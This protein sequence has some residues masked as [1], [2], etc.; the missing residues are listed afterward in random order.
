MDAANLVVPREIW[1][2]RGTALQRRP[3]IAKGVAQLPS[4]LDS[5]FLF[6][7][8]LWPWACCL[9]ECQCE[10]WRR[11]W[12]KRNV[13]SLRGELNGRVDQ[14]QGNDVWKNT[15]HTVG[16]WRHL[17][18]SGSVFIQL[19]G[20]CWWKLA[21]VRLMF[22]ACFVFFLWCVLTMSLPY[23]SFVCSCSWP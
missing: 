4:S 18:R 12:S 11:T 8:G 3:T 19:S 7:T 9:Q 23:I 21:F 6:W 20:C 15:Q 1:Q 13:L 5:V 17:H 16:K 10:V 2:A 22:C 14:P